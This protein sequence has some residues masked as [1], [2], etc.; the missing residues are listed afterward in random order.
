MI[1]ITRAKQRKTRP[2]AGFN[3]DQIAPMISNFELLV[4]EVVCFVP[5]P[6][7]RCLNN[8]ISTQNKRPLMG[9]PKRMN[10]IG[11]IEGC[12]EKNVIWVAHYR[13]EYPSHQ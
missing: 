9:S 4:R 12:L 5:V 7:S 10:P 11:L 6:F 13:D 1:V 3:R 2:K 8:R